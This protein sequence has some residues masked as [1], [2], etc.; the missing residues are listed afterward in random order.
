M[1]RPRSKR[2]KGL[3]ENLYRS[4]KGY[5]SYRNPVTGE[6]TGMGK[7]GNA[8]IAAAKRLNS[9]LD[10]P[11]P[12]ADRVL[13]RDTPTFGKHLD[14]MWKL[15]QDRAMA[16]KLAAKTL[17]DKR[18]RLKYIR[19]TLADYYPNDIS[20]KILNDFLES[21]TPRQATLYRSDLREIFRHA[22][23]RGIYTLP[24]NPADTIIIPDYEK[25]RTRLSY[26]AFMI[27]RHRATPLIQKT[28]DLALHS[29]QRETDL[30]NIRRDT[31]VRIENG[32]MV[33]YVVQHKTKKHGKSAYLRIEVEPPLKAAIDALQDDVVSKWLLHYGLDARRH[34][35]GKPLTAEYVSKGFAA[36][37]NKAMQL[38]GLFKDLA[39]NQLPTFHEIRS[40]GAKLYE[41][42]GIDPQPLLGHTTAKQTQ[43]YLDGHQQ[44]WTTVRAGLAL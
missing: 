19:A 41:D 35:I 25:A 23:A 5:Y 33:L 40:T 44:A 27:I 22:K 18:N 38:D 21:K 16:G 12:L 34:Q 2:N 7:D 9:I 20:I 37:R 6:Y 11:R 3:V 8:A 29:L 4:T 39:P 14:H 15:W 28:M 32:I 1:S 10:K 17:T 43:E 42:R 13:H 26:E 24:D 31:D 36:A 30:V